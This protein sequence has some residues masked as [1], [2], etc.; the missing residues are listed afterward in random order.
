MISV[1]SYVDS[2]QVNG[3]AKHR[4]LT[5]FLPITAKSN[6]YLSEM[7][8]E[9]NKIDSKTLSNKSVKMLG[10]YQIDVLAD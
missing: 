5:G 3:F 8:Q 6:K 9:V 1:Y 4:Q 7:K 10:K 2:S